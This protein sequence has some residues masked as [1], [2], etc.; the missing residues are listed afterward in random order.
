[1]RE[2]LEQLYLNCGATKEK[3]NSLIDD[4]IARAQ[5]RVNEDKKIDIEKNYPNLT[6]EEK[7]TISSYTYEAEEKQYNPY[8]ILNTNLV[9]ENREEGIKNVSKYYLFFLML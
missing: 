7:E 8:R 9:K 1:M 6:L 4:I 3:A 5:K 2:A